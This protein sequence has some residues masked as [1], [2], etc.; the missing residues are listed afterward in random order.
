MK[1]L[2]LLVLLG[3]SPGVAQAANY[4]FSD[5]PGPGGSGTIGDPWCVIP[6]GQTTRISMALLADGT[7]S[8]AANPEFAPGD[9][10][11]LC[12][13]AC[14][15]TGSGVYNVAATAQGTWFL[16]RVNGSAASPIT[17]R[18][19]CNAAGCE[20]ITISG[21]TNGNGVYDSGVDL[22]SFMGNALGS[23]NYYVVDGD[24][25]NTHT[26]HHLIFEKVG[27]VM[28]EFSN[29]NPGVKNWTWNGIEARNNNPVIWNGGD[30]GVVCPTSDQGAYAF[31]LDYMDAGPVTISYSKIHHICRVV[32]RA[33]NNYTTGNAFVFDHNE[34]YN[35]GAVD[36]NNNFIGQASGASQRFSN[37]YVHD[38]GGIYF[39]NNIQHSVIEDNTIGCLGQYL[40]S[41]TIGCVAGIF[42]FDGDSPQCTTN[43]WADDLV[44]RRNRVF[45]TAT[46]IPGY[47][48][49]G[50]YGGM[51]GGILWSANY[52]QGG[53]TAFPTKAV[54]ENNFV[55]WVHPRY[56][57]IDTT[58]FETFGKGGI[59]VLTKTSGLV[60]QNNTVY[61]STYPMIISGAGGTPT[62]TIRDNLVIRGERPGG[63][64]S[65]ELWI[66]S[67][68][69]SSNVQY[70]NI[71]TDGMSG[72]IIDSAGTQYA[73]GSM[74]TFNNGGSRQSNICLSVSFKTV[75]G[76]KDQVDLHLN[77]IQASIDAGCGKSGASH[78]C[79]STANIT[80]DDIDTQQR[81]VGL[82]PD[83]GADEYGSPVT[84]PSATLSLAPA[85]PQH[86]GQT[87][88]KPGTWTVTLVTSAPVVSVPVGLSFIDAS[89]ATVA[90]SLSGSVPGSNFVGTLVVDSGVADGAGSF[91]LPA[92]AL[93]DA[94][95]NKGNAISSG[96]TA[97][98]DKSAP[99]APSN[100]VAR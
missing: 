5:C 97:T 76:A 51:N 35:A 80:A 24:P 98:I 21:D 99:R 25:N 73:C 43:C 56:T 46:T 28:F 15:G 70:N 14:D 71:N 8:G 77:G 32:L 10:A 52:N 57:G 48:Q 18:P 53:A 33:N 65:P 74:A 72:N 47:G 68:A 9:T 2:V 83:I 20:T 75:S 44:V 26:E 67:S 62:F 22:T 100:L 69:G 41:D 1:R 93:V 4:Y 23:K 39:G 13:G 63:G 60:I 3:L 88:L 82:G 29:A 66:D 94:L 45:G 50:Y 38:S 30:L 31:H 49:G 19:Y 40:V 64:H 11:F 90:V 36:D 81:Y 27:G 89:S 91:S 6:T 84:G 96:S 95:G 79:P 85:P 92:N 86:N 58:S 55:W 12:A 42:V 54:I 59:A 37:N 16:P 78:V 17:I 7:N 87:L 61:D 34:V